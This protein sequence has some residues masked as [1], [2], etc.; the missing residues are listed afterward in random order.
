[1]IKPLLRHAPLVATCVLAAACSTSEDKSPSRV[2][3]SS[4]LGRSI[5]AL[6]DLP[7]D[8][9]VAPRQAPGDFD[10][11]GG[12]GYEPEPITEPEPSSRR[13]GDTDSGES[14]VSGLSTGL[15][16]TAAGNGGVGGPTAAGNGGVGG[17][18]SAGNGGVPYNGR[19]VP[20]GGVAIG[21]SSS[22]IATLAAVFCDFLG[23]LCISISRC[24]G[25]SADE[26]CNFDRSECSAFIEAALAEVD[27]PIYV[28]AQA[29]E[30]VRCVGNA[31]ESECLL[32]SGNSA[33]LEARYRACGIVVQSY[34]EH[35]DS[36]EP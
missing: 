19:N 15:T 13:F 30:A 2:D 17:P 7:L 9:E 11:D 36:I 10:P 8:L 1:M 24:S 6:A 18:V 34:V 27:V 28:S 33:A 5:R 12:T 35:D 29:I 25:D 31:L 3:P 16:G 22:S 4:A 14:V 23:S 26:T 21:P 20:P 32:T